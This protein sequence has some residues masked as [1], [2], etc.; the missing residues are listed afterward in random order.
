MKCDTEPAGDDGFQEVATRERQA[1]LQGFRYSTG[2]MTRKALIVGGIVAAVLVIGLSRF[3]SA[4]YFDMLGRAR[5]RT[6]K[7]LNALSN[8]E[9]LGILKA[10]G[11][12]LLP[13]VR[14]I[15]HQCEPAD[16]QGADATLVRALVA[17]APPRLAATAG[18]AEPCGAVTLLTSAFDN[19]V[20]IAHEPN[21][22][23][24]TVSIINTPSGDLDRLK[25][26]VKGI[27]TATGRSCNRLSGA[28]ADVDE[29]F[30][31]P[32]TEQRAFFLVKETGRWRVAL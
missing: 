25:T 2:G 29:L 14:L 27:D 5:S 32:R 23:R 16:L 15:I 26:I 20:S 13:P 31:L 12:R 8:D 7:T 1:N 28:C 18:S 30:R 11:P 21:T 6:T 22:A 24:V 3:T 10:E 4:D 9:A 19:V 17:L